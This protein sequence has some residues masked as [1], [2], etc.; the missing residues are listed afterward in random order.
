[1]KNMIAF[2]VSS[3]RRWVLLGHTIAPRI[4]FWGL[5]CGLVAFDE[6]TL[7]SPPVTFDVQ[8]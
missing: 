4:D 1:M 3:F 2:I 6:H 5:C 8:R 7:S